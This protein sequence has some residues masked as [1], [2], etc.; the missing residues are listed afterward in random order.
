M[1]DAAVAAGTA[2]AAPVVEVV[3]AARNAR[4]ARGRAGPVR[5]VPGSAAAGGPA[6]DRVAAAPGT[7]VGPDAGAVRDVAV[8]PAVAEWVRK[9]V[10]VVVAPSADLVAV[11]GR[12]G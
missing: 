3:A 9:V 2:A 7:G 12:D 8:A 5:G 4:A 11:A 10:A 6:R 1:V